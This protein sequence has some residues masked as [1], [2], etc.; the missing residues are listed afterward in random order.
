MNSYQTKSNVH[1][2]A[3]ALKDELLLTSTQIQKNEEA[4]LVA[5]VIALLAFI[6]SLY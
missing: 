5:R 6:Y 4:S 3:E 1:R 2:R